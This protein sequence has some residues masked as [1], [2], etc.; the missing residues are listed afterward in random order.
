MDIGTLLSYP[1]EIMMP[2]F[3][4]LIA[5]TGLSL[6]DLFLPSRVNRRI[7][8]WISAAAVLAA[9]ISLLTQA[10]SEPAQILHNTYRLDSF[11]ISFKALLLFGTLLVLLIST[12]YLARSDV[13][14]QGE[15][16]YLF[17]A[18]LLGAMMMASSAD[19]I[20]LFVGLELLAIA[21]YIL[22]GIRK[23]SAE[24]NEA[25]MKYAIN[26]GIAT[27][28]TLFGFSYLY[29]LSG[30]TNLGDISR[31][32]SALSADHGH[33]LTVAAFIITFVGLSFKLATV[34]FHMWAPDIYQGSP[35]PVMAFLSVVS[36][37]AGF[38]ILFRVML[39]IFPTVQGFQPDESLYQSVMIFVSI[40]AGLTM[41]IGNILALRQN[42]IKRLFAYSSIAH[43]GYLLVPFVAFSQMMFE[44]TWFYLL[45]YVFM[46]LGALAVLH[47]IISENQSAHISGFAGLYQRSPVLTVCM[48]IFL[49]SLAGIPGTAGFMG[50]LHIFIGALFAD[51]SRYVLVSVM[52]VTTVVSYIYYFSIMLHMYMRPPKRY[53]KITWP[54]GATLTIALCVA[55]TLLLGIFPGAALQFLQE[56]FWFNDMFTLN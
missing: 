44:S 56:Y 21:S 45:A 12:S 11:S 15:W 28:V 26:G 25:A 47:I 18:A 6:T 13:E 16:Y 20:T 35:L 54:I 43:A 10:G 42:N 48:T 14:E 55:G 39:S 27:A 23:K 24:S 41:I 3:I 7:F 9:L 19:L 29:G 38:I 8:G 36:K 49:L 4:I 5:A 22:T 30:S 2:E 17:L 34:P 46:N 53:T 52:L 31:E 40:A 33:A 37:T 51:P 50:K 32:I 1:W